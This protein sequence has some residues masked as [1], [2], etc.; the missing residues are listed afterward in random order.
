MKHQHTRALIAVH[1]HRHCVWGRFVA[2]V[3]IMVEGRVDGWRASTG[4]LLHAWE[5]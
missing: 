5:S 4:H 2:V 3:D 1:F